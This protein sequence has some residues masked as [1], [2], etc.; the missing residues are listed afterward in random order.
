ME[1][2]LVSGEEDGRELKKL[3]QKIVKL[4]LKNVQKKFETLNLPDGF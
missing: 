2:L 1:C 3:N 4:V